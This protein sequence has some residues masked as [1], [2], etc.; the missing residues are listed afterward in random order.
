MPCLNTAQKAITGVKE[1]TPNGGQE[2]PRQMFL[3][4]RVAYVQRGLSAK[5][6]CSCSFRQTKWPQSFSPSLFQRN[7]KL[8]CGCHLRNTQANTRGQQIQETWTKK[9]TDASAQNMVQNLRI[10]PPRTAEQRQD[11]AWGEWRKFTADLFRLFPRILQCESAALCQV[12]LGAS[13]TMA[14]EGLGLQSSYC[15]TSAQYGQACRYVR[16]TQVK[17]SNWE[18]DKVEIFSQCIFWRKNNSRI[19]KRRRLQFFQVLILKLHCVHHCRM[20][21]GSVI[22]NWQC[23]AVLKKNGPRR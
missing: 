4:H 16:E 5:H 19:H 22:E 18:T 23:N 3:S 7:G 11:E 15:I 9:N 2:Q 1:A 12:D 20:K 21:E 14:Q 6:F 8:C 17:D 13:T 10:H